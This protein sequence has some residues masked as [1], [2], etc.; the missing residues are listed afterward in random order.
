M[1][2]GSMRSRLSKILFAYRLTPQTTTGVAPAEL[3]IG[4]RPRSRLDLLKPHTADKVE[5]KQ[6]VQHDRKAQGR[7]FGVGDKVFVRNYHQGE[8]WLPGV[9]EKRTGPVCR[10]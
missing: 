8:K 1:K 4:R 3:L 2:T 6:K 9:V 5:K 7:S 10:F